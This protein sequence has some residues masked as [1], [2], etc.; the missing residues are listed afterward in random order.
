MTQVDFY[1]L[2]T[3]DA[4]SRLRFVCRLA[5]RAFANQCKLH[6]LSASRA[7]C[8]I[9]DHLLWSH[10]DI[11][12]LPHSITHAA[13]SE[14]PITLGYTTESLT[15]GG[16]LVNLSPEIP[17][18]YLAFEQVAEI[19]DEDNERKARGRQHYRIYRERGCVLHHHQ[20]ETA[21]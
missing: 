8:H 15:G 14:Y 3:Q 10:D 17:A 2:P 20:L 18:H 7:E 19:V 6:I 12:F 1:L 21:V 9:L 16:A 11:S 13:D 4:T 5:S